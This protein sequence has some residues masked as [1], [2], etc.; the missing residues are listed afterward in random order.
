MKKDKSPETKDFNPKTNYDQTLKE[1][2][3]VPR[4]KA[5]KSDYER[6]GFMSGLE[7]HQQL[8]QKKNYSVIAL[9]EFF[10]NTTILMQKLFVICVR[11]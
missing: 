5:K 11:H 2:G 10:I 7:V 4:K 6:I 9:L 3:Y 8:K 1:V